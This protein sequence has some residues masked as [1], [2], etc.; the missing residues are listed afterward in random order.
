MVKEYNTATTEDDPCFNDLMW[1][2]VED[3]TCNDFD[4]IKQN[5]SDRLKCEDYG[6]LQDTIS[7]ETADNS[8]CVCGGGYRNGNLTGQKL[9]VGIPINYDS[10]YYW[11]N[12]SD[13][14]F[15]GGSI[16]EYT[17]KTAHSHGFGM[18]PTQKFSSAANKL[19]PNDTWNGCV[20]DASRGNVDLC[21]GNFWE[22]LNRGNKGL[23]TMDFF[24][25]HFI[26]VSPV[27][28]ISILQN[29]FSVGQGFT[30]QAWIAILCMIFYMGFVMN[31]VQGHVCKKPENDNEEDDKVKI[32]KYSRRGLTSFIFRLCYMSIRSFVSSDN[33]ES[34]DTPSRSEQI[35]TV[36]FVVC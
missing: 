17:L 28:D 30:W 34:T 18:Y 5:A 23:R 32:D 33:V 3:K 26:L 7:E 10:V 8:C 11:F 12:L 19:Y 6:Y 20:Y 25:N 31:I 24:P 2:T 1:K 4:H 13:G 21:L 16:V 14:N 27:K 35:I 36:G 15:T 22:T 9:R 29:M